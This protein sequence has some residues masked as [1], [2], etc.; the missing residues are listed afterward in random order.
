M[1]NV[2]HN[3]DLGQVGLPTLVGKSCFVIVK[4]KKPYTA[5]VK[6][7]LCILLAVFGFGSLAAAQSSYFGV[8]FGTPFLFEVHYGYDFNAVN[9]GFGIRAFF[10]SSLLGGSSSVGLGLDALLRTPIGQYGSSAFVGLSSSVTFSFNNYNYNPGT[11]GS[12]TVLLGI[13]LGIELSIG[14]GWS[15][16]F[17]MQ[18]MSLIIPSNS[19]AQFQ[20]LPLLSFGVNARF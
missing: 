14:E 20:T 3:S 19:N 4:L 7:I 13:L 11:N 2:H 8:K 16:L 10:G 6:K 15:L 18:P 1:C 9:K 12:V 17:E 5:R